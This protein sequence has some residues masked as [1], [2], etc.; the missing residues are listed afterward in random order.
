MF[1]FP[2][3]T[4][5][6]N[7]HVWMKT[8][9]HI[10]R[11]FSILA[12]YS[13]IWQNIRYSTDYLVFGQVFGFSRIFSIFLQPN[14]RFGRISK[15]AVRSN[16]NVQWTGKRAAASYPVA[17]FFA[18]LP[19]SALITRGNK[20]CCCKK[21]KQ[22]KWQRYSEDI[23]TLSLKGYPLFTVILLLVFKFIP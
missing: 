23:L 3:C 15:K 12:D 20:F 9:R 21:D 13:T 8:I 4:F 10:R 22:E 11:I 16:T 17:L 14:I 7:I 6:K 18:L 5:T 1:T 19:S 2:T